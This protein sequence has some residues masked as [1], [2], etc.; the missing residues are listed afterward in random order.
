MA[1]SLTL[2]RALALLALAGAA[3][4]A[5]LGAGGLVAGGR[6]ASRAPE[7][8]PDTCTTMFKRMKS[9]GGTVPPSEF[10]VGCTEVCKKV[11]E[12]KEY[13][14]SGETA[15]HACETGKSYGCV[16]VGTPPVTLADIGC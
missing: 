13:W 6:A 15:D 11:K 3:G 4:A 1:A 12:M 2:V 10:V 7:F 5:K 9:L 8:A 14:G 16:W